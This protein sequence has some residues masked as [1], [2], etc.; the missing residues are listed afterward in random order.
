MPE[1]SDGPQEPLQTDDSRMSER[2]D[3]PQEPLQTDDS[4]MPEIS[5]GPQ[6]P[7]QTA[8]GDSIAAS[9]LEAGPA[10]ESKD[11]HVGLD[12]CQEATDQEESENGMALPDDQESMSSPPIPFPNNDNVSS[13]SVQVNGLL[14][15]NNTSSD[16]SLSLKH[17]VSIS[18]RTASIDDEHSQERQ[19]LYGAF[20]ISLKSIIHRYAGTGLAIEDGN[21]DLEQFCS[22]V[23]HVFLHGFRAKK[24]FWSLGRRGSYWVRD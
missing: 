9:N 16:S 17:S 7:L 2:S 20:Q 14:C 3:G 6:E 15:M 23:E 18:S 22:V 10:M 21:P 11:S 13:S 5:D 19:A 8:S 1:I 12:V 24:S 4:S